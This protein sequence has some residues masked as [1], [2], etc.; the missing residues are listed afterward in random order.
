[1]LTKLFGLYPFGRW[2]HYIA[3]IC[4]WTSTNVTVQTNCNVI[5]SGDYS[6][7]IMHA[8]VSNWTRVKKHG[9]PELYAHQI[10]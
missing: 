7:N 9:Y 5:K 6:N 2:I 1:L 4:G 3:Y 8:F 10:W